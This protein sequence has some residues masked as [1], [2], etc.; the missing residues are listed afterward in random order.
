MINE[1]LQDLKKRFETLSFVR[2]LAQ[3]YDKELLEY[4]LNESKFSQEFKNRFFIKINDILLF[5]QSDFLT[6]LDFK[7]LNGSYSAFS[8]KIGLGN[9]NKAFLK[10]N[11]EVVLNFAFKDCVLKGGQSKDS[12]KQN[13]IFFNEVLAFDEIDVLFK[14]K[15]LC[16]FEL[17]SLTSRSGET[18]PCDERLRPLDHPKQAERS[19]LAKDSGT[20]APRSE[21][22]TFAVSGDSLKDSVCM[23]GGLKGLESN[24][25]KSL[26]L[27]FANPDSNDLDSTN[28][29][30]SADDSKNTDSKNVKNPDFKDSKN[31][32]S[33]S[34]DSADSKDSLNL[35]SANVD[36]KNADSKDSDSQDSKTPKNTDSSDLD[37]L[38]SALKDSPNLLIKGNNLLALHSIKKKFAKQVKLIYIDPPYNTGNDSFNYNDRFSH[39]TW[40]VFMKNRLEVA[41][42]FLRDDGVIFIQCD[43]NEQAYLKVLCDEIFGR[44]N[45][46]ANITWHRKRGKDNS[47]KFLSRVGEYILVYAKSIQNLAFSKIELEQQTLEQYQNPDNDSRGKYRKLAL[48]R[49]RGQGGSRAYSYT[50]NSGVF[51]DSK[52]WLVSQQTMQELDNANKLIVINNNLYRKLF[53]N[54]HDGSIPETIWINLSNTANAKDE[55]KALFLD[56]QNERSIFDDKLGLCSLE[57]GNKTWASIDEAKGKLPDLSQ[58]DKLFSTPKPEALL[59]R[60]IEISTQENDLVMDFFA[61]SGTTLAVAHKMNR[62]YIGIEQMDYIES[63]TKER[64]KKVVNGEQGG[65]SKAVGWNPKNP[66]LDK[67]DKYYAKNSFIYMELMPLNVAYKEKIENLNDESNLTKI[68]DELKTKA[69]IDY[70]VDIREMLKDGEFE[71]LE[72]E[73]KKKILHLILDSNMDYVLYGDIKDGDY[74][75]DELTKKLNDIFYKNAENGGENE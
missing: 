60:I 65:I 39:S 75:I 15:V 61:G 6:F 40:L 5:K 74:N 28:S 54:E 45:F 33:K 11:Y 3:K 1:L 34:T 12:Q 62:R 30:D 16:N 66:D 27:D 72:L 49:R 69:F 48:W 37:S 50:T 29:A 46:V 64:L 35:D 58:K 18:T 68:Y 44:E 25:E 73:S 41:R 17:I 20:D 22:F 31:P 4:L 53:L 9:K 63:I 57:Q 2:N 8:S 56:S 14:P 38:I 7:M 43:D 59:K 42:E 13:E 52:E 21:S 71:S 23:G 24:L 19:F 26:S 67:N 47:A 55:I 32:D 70:R 51:I 36:S 10:T